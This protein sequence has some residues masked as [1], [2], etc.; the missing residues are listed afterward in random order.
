LSAALVLGR[1]RRR[2]VV[3]DDGRP[4][5]A[6][7]EAL[8]GFLTRDGIAPAELLRIG[9]AQL[10]PYA[11]VRIVDG[12]VTDARRV[13]DGF[14][15]DVD[16]AAFVVAPTLL[17]A[18]GVRDRLPEVEGFETYYG[19]GVY[20]CPY[21][22]GWELRE[23]PLAAYGPGAQAARLA[24]ALTPWSADVALCTDGAD[25]LG[26]DD[27]RDL[28]AHGIPVYTQPVFRLEGDAER[29]SAVRFADGSSLRRAALF[30]ALGVSPRCGLAARLGCPVTE[31]RGAET[32]KLARTAVPGLFVAGDASRDVALAI[33][34][35]AE[36]AEAAVA[37][38]KLLLRSP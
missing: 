34:A 5:N 10:A 30:F 19:R 15:L 29:L 33:V 35:A 24:V 2:V 22:D 12:Q 16:G 26:D 8:H 3:V 7:S 1:C 21:C 18:T 32:E 31:E 20:H 13:D 17:L 28:A 6:A 38:N 25:E 9:R 4:R 37:M 36:G 27:R 23:R 14:V 11:S